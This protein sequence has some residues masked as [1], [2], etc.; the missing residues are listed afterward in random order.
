M[1]EESACHILPNLIGARAVE[2]RATVGVG[3]R[4]R[5][6]IVEQKLDI[7]HVVATG[8]VDGRKRKRRGKGS[9]NERGTE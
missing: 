9:V 5:R 3:G 8:A 2:R 4:R 6:A 7:D 1:N